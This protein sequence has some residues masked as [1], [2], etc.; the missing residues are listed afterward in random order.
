MNTSSRLEA[1]ERAVNPTGHRI[2]SRCAA[3][4]PVRQLQPGERLEQTV[5]ATCPDC[6]SLIQIRIVRGAAVTRVRPRGE[7]WTKADAESLKRLMADPVAFDEACQLAD[8]V[9]SLNAAQQQR[10]V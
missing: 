2:C 7:K 6:G 1:L 5:D 3:I 10:K 8:E 4:P 9:Q